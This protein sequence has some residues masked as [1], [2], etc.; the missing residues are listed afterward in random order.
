MQDTKGDF[1]QAAQTYYRAANGSEF[2]ESLLGWSL[3][4]AILSPSGP[5]KSRLIAV[6]H[7]DERLKSNQFYDLLGKMFRGERIDVNNV[8][9][10]KDTLEEYQN[11]MKQGYTVLERAIIEH[12]ILCTSKLYMNITFTE[13]GNFLGISP[14]KAED[15]VSKMVSEGRISAVLDQQADLIEFEDEGHQV[16]TFN[17]QIK[18]TCEKVDTL[19]NDMLKQYPDLARFDTFTF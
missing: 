6:L 13:L 19:M 11:V 1:L 18:E 4:A 17:S 12:N 5:T 2:D 9:E 3:K 15:F 16:H 10:F 7:N 14:D 8:Q